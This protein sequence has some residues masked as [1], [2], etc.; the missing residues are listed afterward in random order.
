MRKP[1]SDETKINSTSEADSGW[2]RLWKRSPESPF[3]FFF[4]CP[5]YFKV[6]HSYTFLFILLSPDSG[7]AGLVEHCVIS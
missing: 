2:Q 4:L 1:S 6:R 7:P 3:F 5:F